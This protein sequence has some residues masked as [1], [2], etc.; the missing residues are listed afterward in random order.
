MST[1]LAEGGGVPEP[2]HVGKFSG[3]I[4]RLGSSPAENR[5]FLLEKKIQGKIPV[6]RNPVGMAPVTRVCGQ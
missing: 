2:G 3:A 4:R 1:F 5:E 6:P